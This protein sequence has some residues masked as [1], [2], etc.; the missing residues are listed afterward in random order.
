ML[1]YLALLRVLRVKF[2]GR[3][4][5]SARRGREGWVRRVRSGVVDAVLR[6]CWLAV[7]S[8]LQEVG[9][10]GWSR[11]LRGVFVL[12]SM[13]VLLWWARSSGSLCFQCSVLGVQAM[14]MPSFVS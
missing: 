6:A 13:Q 1:Q 5:V 8:C 14:S 7:F 11:V 2:I 12:G 9:E 10:G 4:V 3:V